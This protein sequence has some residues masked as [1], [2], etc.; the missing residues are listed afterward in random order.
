M[1][2]LAHAALPP[3]LVR[4]MLGAQRMEHG[5]AQ[6]AQKALIN[7]ISNVVGRLPQKTAV[8]VTEEMIKEA[9]AKYDTEELD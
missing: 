7:Y 2:K 4:Q 1:A 6:E 9:V 8:A 3:S 5:V